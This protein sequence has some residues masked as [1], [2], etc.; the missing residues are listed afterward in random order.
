MGHIMDTELEFGT[1]TD[2]AR[3]NEIHVSWESSNR[4][5]LPKDMAYLLRVEYED[6][7]QQFPHALSRIL[8]KLLFEW[9]KI[10]GRSN[11]KIAEKS[12]TI[13]K[14]YVL[15]AK[16]LFKEVCDSNASEPRVLVEATGLMA[17]FVRT[18]NILQEALLDFRKQGRLG[19]GTK[20]EA[21]LDVSMGG[22]LRYSQWM[23]HLGKNHRT[24]PFNC[25]CANIST[26]VIANVFR[27][28]EGYVNQLLN[29]SMS[30][31]RTELG[32]EM[33]A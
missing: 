7:L 4:C 33:T 23:H 27:S 18:T 26:K 21:D 12:I 17:N 22:L 9:T 14:D 30:F 11:L 6:T 31:L 28:D 20:I 25:A 24:L 5:R 2:R 1:E 15:E 10:T 3:F 13:K 32:R 8:E 19:C 29:S 16:N